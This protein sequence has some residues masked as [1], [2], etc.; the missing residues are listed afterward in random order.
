MARFG[1][2]IDCGLATSPDSR[3]PSTWILAQCG[4]FRFLLGPLG[5]ASHYARLLASSPRIVLEVAS[6]SSTAE[7]TP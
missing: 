4:F 2:P 6:K 5:V 7:L 1:F 3:H